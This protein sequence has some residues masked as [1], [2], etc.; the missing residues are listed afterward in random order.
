M[1]GEI[2][3]FTCGNTDDTVGDCTHTTALGVLLTETCFCD[4]D[5][6]NSATK[7]FPKEKEM[8]DL[9]SPADTMKCKDAADDAVEADGID[10]ATGFCMVKTVYSDNTCEYI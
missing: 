1:Y 6:C 3:I 5:L 4:S 8:R 2:P 10:C 7:T 9:G